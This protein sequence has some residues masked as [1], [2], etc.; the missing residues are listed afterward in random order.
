MLGYYKWDTVLANSSK[1][2][3]VITDIKIM[4]TS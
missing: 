2:G 1:A 3:N 4:L